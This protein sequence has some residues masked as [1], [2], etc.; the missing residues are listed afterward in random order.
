MRL[1]C[2]QVDSKIQQLT[3]EL[4]RLSKLLDISPTIS[5]FQ[6]V[7]LESNKSR[8]DIDTLITN[9]STNLQSSIQGN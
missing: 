9:V 4:D 7:I 6:K 8:K 5:E 2:K 3:F 1:L